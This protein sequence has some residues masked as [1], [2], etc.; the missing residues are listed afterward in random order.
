MHPPQAPRL[1]DV[2]ELERGQDDDRPERRGREIAEERRQDEQRD[3]GRPE[4]MIPVNCVRPPLWRRRS[5]ASRC[6]SRESRGRVRSRSSPRRGRG[7]RGSRRISS[8][9]ARASPAPQGCCSRTRAGRCSPPAR[10]GSQVPEGHACGSPGVGTPRGTVAD[11]V[12]RVRKSCDTDEH[13][14]Q[15]HRDQAGWDLAGRT[16]ERDRH[17]RGGRARSRQP[18]AQ[19]SLLRTRP[20]SRTGTGLVVEIPVT[21]VSWLITITI[22]EPAR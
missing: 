9:S 20:R 22:P 11:D 8:R 16:R 18:K 12:D 2:D 19:R 4:A 7:T 3:D 15:R 13:G 17:D 21:F 1:T 6:R 5:S 10:A 14:G